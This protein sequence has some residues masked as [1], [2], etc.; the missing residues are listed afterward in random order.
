MDTFPPVFST[1]H[2]LYTEQNFHRPIMSLPLPA[3]PFMI[4]QKVEYKLYI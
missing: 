4:I 1:N 2:C 3:G